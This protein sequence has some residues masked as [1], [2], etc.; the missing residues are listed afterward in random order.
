MEKS[1][2]KSF[3]ISSTALSMIFFY[4]ALEKLRENYRNLN[5]M[6]Q[7]DFPYACEDFF[8]KRRV[9]RHIFVMD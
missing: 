6:A 1:T 3:Q 9:K 4:T 7:R 2:K 5:N 8:K